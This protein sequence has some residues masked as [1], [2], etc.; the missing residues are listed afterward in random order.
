MTHEGLTGDV[1][2]VAKSLAHALH[3]FGYEI[4]DVRNKE[5]VQLRRVELGREMSPAEMT[6][7]EKSAA[8]A[9]TPSRSLTS[10]DASFS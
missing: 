1:T 7:V 9:E 2:S 5:C 6:L 4:H 3:Y 8:G 10:R